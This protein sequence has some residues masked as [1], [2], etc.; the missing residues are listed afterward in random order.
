[1]KKV[2]STPTVILIKILLIM[3]M[4]GVSRAN[5]YGEWAHVDITSPQNGI[6]QNST[7]PLQIWVYVPQWNKGISSIVSINYN[8]DGKHNITLVGSLAGSPAHEEDASA[9]GKLANLAEGNHNIIAYANLVDGR[10]IKSG[11]TFTVNTTFQCPEV[12]ILS[13]LNQRTYTAK[14][15]PLIYNIDGQVKYATYTL[16][17]TSAVN[18]RVEGFVGNT[19]LSRLSEGQHT[20]YL[21][22]LTELNIYTQET[23]N[24]TVLSNPKSGPESFPITPFAAGV[25][26]VAAVIG[27]A[28]LLFHNR[29][30]RREA[31]QT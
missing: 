21:S 25:A 12:T 24:F 11:C 19:T 22:V 29:K 23:A 17:N 13:P 20:I 8:I 6:Y 30:R 31:Q 28:G 18:A 4:V 26:A 1:M 10:V 14:E 2:I 5:P 15:V 3:P 9:S 16:D 7:I 27:T